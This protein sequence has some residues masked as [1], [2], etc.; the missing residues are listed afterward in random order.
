MD[1]GARQLRVGETALVHMTA[2]WGYG[3][4]GFPAYVRR[5]LTLSFRCKSPLLTIC[6]LQLGYPCELPSCLRDHHG[7][8]QVKTSLP[9]LANPLVCRRNIRIGHYGAAKPPTTQ[10]QHS[11]QK[12]ALALSYFSLFMAC[13]DPAG[14]SSSIQTHN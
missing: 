1:A 14:I 6:C 7:Q 5:S 3:A 2:D 10:I 8:L 13:V 4:N 12:P 11:S 9:N